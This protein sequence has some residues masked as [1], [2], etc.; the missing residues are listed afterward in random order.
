MIKGDIKFVL[1]SI[2]N[3]IPGGTGT[4]HL[5]LDNT[6]TDDTFHLSLTLTTRNSAIESPISGHIAPSTVRL[7]QGEQT[8]GLVTLRADQAA[9]AGDSV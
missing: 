8:A 2:E 5:V 6:G 1:L 9:N 7:E 3:L 4:F